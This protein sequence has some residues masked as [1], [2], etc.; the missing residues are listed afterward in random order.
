MSFGSFQL[1][2]HSKVYES[3]FTFDVKRVVQDNNIDLS[4]WYEYETGS[5][6]SKY[7]TDS[8]IQEFYNELSLMYR[9]LPIWS[10]LDREHLFL[11]ITHF[12]KAKNKVP[13]LSEVLDMVAQ[14]H[15]MKKNKVSISNEFHPVLNEGVFAGRFNFNLALLIHTMMAGNPLKDSLKKEPANVLFD[16]NNNRI[17]TISDFADDVLNRCN[18]GASMQEIIGLIKEKYQMPY[19]K[20]ESKC[21]NFLKGLIEKNMIYDR[22]V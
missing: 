17:F 22:A 15:I 13:E 19:E 9:D 20:A 4:L 1:T 3:P 10:N 8:M 14:K 21:M 5:G 18:G 11:Y 12:K 7:E 2:K 16:I 6:M